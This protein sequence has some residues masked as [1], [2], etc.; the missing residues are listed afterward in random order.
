MAKARWKVLRKLGLVA[1]LCVLGSCDTGGPDPQ[2]RSTIS[3]TLSQGIRGVVRYGYGTFWI[4]N[5]YRQCGMPVEREVRVHELTT[6]HPD[7]VDIV[8]IDVNKGHFFSAIHTELVAVVQSECRKGRFEVELRPGT[9]SVFLVE[10]GLFYARA[11]TPDLEISPV[12]VRRGAFADIRID[13]WYGP[14]W[15]P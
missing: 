12:E 1:G 9:Y 5:E 10:D 2:G 13:I 15:P 4:A 3:P 8:S 14:T 7:Q 11:L 6:L